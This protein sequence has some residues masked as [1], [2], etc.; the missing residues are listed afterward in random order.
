MNDN[1]FAVLA[2]IIGTTLTCVALDKLVPEGMW[3][4]LIALVAGTQITMMSIRA[5][6]KQ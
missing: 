1:I 2:A 4:Y 6:I 3:L 5:V